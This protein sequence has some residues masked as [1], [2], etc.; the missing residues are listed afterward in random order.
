MSV[1]FGVK[2]STMKS[3]QVDNFYRYSLISRPGIWAIFFMLHLLVYAF[4]FV[5]FSLSFSLRKGGQSGQEVTNYLI[6]RYQYGSILKVLNNP[7]V[8]RVWWLVNMGTEILAVDGNN[9]QL[10][11]MFLHT[12]LAYVSAHSF[13]LCFCTQLWPIFV[14]TSLT[15]V[16]GR[17]EFITCP[18]CINR[19]LSWTCH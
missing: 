2:F 16:S 7:R 5:S 11:P 9:T 19:L 13:G 4:L 1:R 10:W 12:A 8:C 18:V 6:S 14:H 17:R 3:T 15:Y